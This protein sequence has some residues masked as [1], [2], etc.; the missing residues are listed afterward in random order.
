MISLIRHNYS[1]T[2]SA[3]VSI[4]GIHLFVINL[5]ALTVRIMLLSVCCFFKSHLWVFNLVLVQA[6]DTVEVL[7]KRKNPM[8]ALF[9]E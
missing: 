8:R 5:G 6:A 7:G 2:W 9:S 3:A 1:Q 4:H